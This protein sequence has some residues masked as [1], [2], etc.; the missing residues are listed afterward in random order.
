M[1]P[2]LLIA[3]RFLRA[4]SRSAAM[5][6]VGIAFGVAFFVL[7]QAQTRGFEEFFIKTIL[8]T[9]GAVRISEKYQDTK[10]FVVVETSLGEAQ[11]GWQ[12]SQRNYVEGIDYPQA[13]RA[14]LQ[15]IP[16]ITGI[17]EVIEGSADMTFGGRTQKVSLMGVRLFD[18]L[19]VSALQGQV[20]AGD[21][22][23]FESKVLPVVIG[24][25]LA[26][27]LGLEPG[28]KVLLGASSETV[29]GEVVAVFQTGAGDID[30]Q[31]VYLPIGKARE[32][33]KKP[34]GGSVFLLS[35]ADVATA[36]ALAR[37]IDKTYRYHAVSWQEREKVWLDVFAALRVSSGLTVS[38]ILVIA[39]MGIFN[40]LTMMVLEKTRQIA[41]LSAMGYGARDIRAVFLYQGAFL[42]GVGCTL[43]V[44]LGALATFLVEKLPIKIRG[45]FS[46]DHFVVSWDVWHY[47][48]A[49]A[50]A[51]LA[52]VIATVWPAQRASKLAPAEILRGGGA[53]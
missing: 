53:Q 50:L 19:Q 35:V 20:I 34:F 48:L 23:D 36:P 6:I 41:I 16:E 21:L 32:L 9:N 38:S 46:T 39:A 28:Q 11:V 12:A 4:Q 43:G 18:Q 24:V 49:V 44:A 22:T 3:W 1:A 14:E 27:R 40:T 26:K 52:V 31:R 2:T 29:L 5:G 45:I 15:K 33:L 17:S 13:L 10:D 47:L 8:G 37:M 42:G 25:R 7:T 30:L 51:L